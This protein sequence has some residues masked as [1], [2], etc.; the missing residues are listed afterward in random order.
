M[1]PSAVGRLIIRLPQ[2]SVVVIHDPRFEGRDS[3]YAMQIVNI[4]HGYRFF[5]V[6]NE[7]QRKTRSSIFIHIHNVT[8]RPAFFFLC[9]YTN[10]SSILSRR[11]CTVD[12]SSV[13]S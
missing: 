7:L 2:A 3:R 12:G 10:A 1:A 5:F 9:F 8:S 11:R 6:S 13:R 4:S